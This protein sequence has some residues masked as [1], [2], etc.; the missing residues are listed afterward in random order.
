MRKKIVLSLTLNSR[1][2]DVSG[3]GVYF[4][5]RRLLD[6]DTIEKIQKFLKVTKPAYSANF[7][8]GSSITKH[9][10]YM[11]IAPIEKIGGNHF[12]E[13]V[14]IIQG[15]ADFHV[16]EFKRFVLF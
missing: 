14:P 15:K 1:H 11:E 3:I 4:I 2:C 5:A 12:V 7:N 8:V 6:F 9:I 10:F 13:I 16:N